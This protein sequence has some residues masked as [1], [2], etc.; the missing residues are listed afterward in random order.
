[1]F[2]LFASTVLGLCSGGPDCHGHEMLSVLPL[3]WSMEVTSAGLQEELI[4]LLLQPTCGHLNLETISYLVLTHKTLDFGQFCYC[5]SQKH[6]FF[7]RL[8]A[9]AYLCHLS[10]RQAALPAVLHPS[11]FQI[12]HFTQWFRVFISPISEE[13]QPL[14]N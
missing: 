1:M 13:I 3:V 6:L 8:S 5:H 10:H 2:G 9:V 11:S 12:G 4:Q 14:Q 7:F